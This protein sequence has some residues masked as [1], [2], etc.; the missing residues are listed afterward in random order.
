MDEMDDLQQRFETSVKNIKNK[1]TPTTN[2]DLLVL[3]GLY[4]QSTQG[5]CNIPQPWSIQVE[6]RAKW[7]A[8]TANSH[9]T[10]CQAMQKYIQ[11]VND[12]IQS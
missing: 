8:W 3:Y 9:M 6:Q 4:K 5:N 2:E 1:T 12:L 11:K 7:D 10:K